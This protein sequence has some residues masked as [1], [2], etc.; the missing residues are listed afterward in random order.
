[1]GGRGIELRSPGNGPYWVICVPLRRSPA[2]QLGSHERMTASGNWP[3]WVAQ[4]R[5]K[6][7]IRAA[8]CLGTGVRPGVA[9]IRM[10][11]GFRCST[12]WLLGFSLLLLG[13]T[14]GPGGRGSAGRVFCR[15]GRGRAA[16]LPERAR[17]GDDD[18]SGVENEQQHGRIVGGPGGSGSS[19]R[20]LTTRS[21]GSAGQQRSRRWSRS[22]PARW[23][24]KST[25]PT[26]A[27]TAA[28]P[29]SSDHREET[30]VRYKLLGGMGL[31]VSEVALGTMTFGT[32]WGRRRAE[33]PSSSSCSPRSAAPSSTPPTTTP[34]AAPRPF[35]A[36]CWQPTASTSSTPSTRSTSA[37]A[38]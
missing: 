28:A 32:D 13:W 2:S 10:T 7:G 11:H 9:R 14:A 19:P 6:P 15:P 31:R 38:T 22:W 37:A 27:S 35:S 1:M 23:S 5:M 26:C 16:W 24:A 3:L 29:P 21:V 8:Q 20:C 12:T 18:A 4:T 36:S 17:V 33:A 34:T 30:A 25:A